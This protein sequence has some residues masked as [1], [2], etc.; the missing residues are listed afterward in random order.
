MIVKFV[1]LNEKTSG[2]DINRM[3]VP[4]DS[5]ELAGRLWSDGAGWLPTPWPSIVIIA[6]LGRMSRRFGEGWWGSLAAIGNLQTADPTQLR[7]G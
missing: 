5:N 3:S 1:G 4:Y 6:Q 7:S 2:N